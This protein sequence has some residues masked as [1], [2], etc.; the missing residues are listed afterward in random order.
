M[1]QFVSISISP[2]RWS[3]A[4]HGFQA[5]TARERE[6]LQDLANCLSAKEIARSRGISHRTVEV[7][8]AKIKFK[9]GARNLAEVL[10]TIY[11]LAFNLE[12]DHEPDASP[13]NPRWQIGMKVKKHLLWSQSL[14]N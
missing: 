3:I 1:Q 6:I 4:E 10:Q 11:A 5:L 8:K 2:E 13:L 14:Q 7:H 9:L 12:T